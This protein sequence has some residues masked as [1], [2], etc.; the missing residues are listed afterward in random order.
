[1]KA[2][3]T[4]KE[5]P[6]PSVTVDCVIF[7]YRNDSLQVLL[8]QRI[9]EPYKGVFALP[10]GFVGVDETLNDAAKRAKLMIGMR[11]EYSFIFDNCH[12]FTAGCLSG[13]FE[14]STNFFSFLNDIVRNNISGNEWRVWAL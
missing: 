13:D 10:G 3:P 14:N 5:Y 8:S 12:Q 11:R 7:G 6:K 2:K 9:D 4:T 1:M